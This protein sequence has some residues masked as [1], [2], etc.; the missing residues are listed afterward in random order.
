MRFTVSPCLSVMVRLVRISAAMVTTA[1]GM[2]QAVRWLSRRLPVSPPEV[3]TASVCPPKE[4]T[5]QEELMPRP[6]ADSRLDLM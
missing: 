5:T 6:P 4:C 3:S 2:P 1:M